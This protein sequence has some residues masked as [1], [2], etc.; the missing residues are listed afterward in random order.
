MIE[1]GI[2]Q[3]FLVGVGVSVLALCAVEILIK[4]NKI[5]DSAQKSYLYMIALFSCFS[6]ILYTPFFVSISARGDQLVL[7]FPNTVKEITTALN[8]GI[9][10]MRGEF[11]FVNFRVI[12]L[13][14]MIGSALFFVF[15]LGFSRYYIVKRYSA[16]SCKDKRI[17]TVLEKVCQDM[18]MRKPDVLS[19]KGVNAFVFGIPPVLAVGT[20][21]IENT[22]E[23]E[24]ELVIRHEMNHIKNFDHVLKPFFSSLRILFFIN[25]VVH[26]LSQKIAEER[27]FLADNVSETR[28][29][30]L[31]F[32]YTLVRLCELNVDRTK[33]F[34]SALFSPL[35]RPNLTMRKEILFSKSKKRRKYTYFVFMGV[36]AILLVAGTYVSSG[37]WSGKPLFRGVEGV[38]KECVG[39]GIGV[40]GEK[41]GEFGI[42]CVGEHGLPP[43]I[44]HGLRESMGRLKEARSFFE[45]AHI[46]YGFYSIDVDVLIGLI[47]IFLVCGCVQYMRDVYILG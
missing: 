10:S 39:C 35:I 38:G 46:E 12:L 47:A 16:E 34:S 21:L 29:D 27:E 36:F 1:P 6:S 3:K 19:I 30:R 37:F 24:L 17:L 23:K 15:A 11:L 25:P 18:N 26:V 28:K 44:S 8:S 33:G 5:D 45:K 41:F 7:F 32:M 43:G 22:N 4:V 2:L 31:L 14:L 9:V 20:D 13:I 42:G 40:T